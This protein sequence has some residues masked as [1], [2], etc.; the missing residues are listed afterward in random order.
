MVP[1]SIG[2]WPENYSHMNLNVPGGIAIGLEIVICCS[3]FC[4]LYSVETPIH[5]TNETK[6]RDKKEH[7]EHD[8]EDQAPK[9]TD[10]YH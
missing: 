5:V 3:S 9:P 1:V 2:D 8:H 6:A 4:C 7:N 10:K